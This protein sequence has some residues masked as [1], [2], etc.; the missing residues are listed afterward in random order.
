MEEKAFLEKLSN[1]VVKCYDKNGNI[2]QFKESRIQKYK[3]KFSSTGRET[4][5]LFLDGKP[6][7]GKNKKVCYICPTCQ[8]ES[9]IHL[10]RFLL[11]NTVHCSHC[12]E[13]EEKREWHSKVLKSYAKGEKIQLKDSLKKKREYNWETESETFKREY[14]ESHLTSEE[15]YSLIDKNYL[16]SINGIPIKDKK[17]VYYPHEPSTNAKKYRAMV[18]IDGKKQ[19]FGDKIEI[20]CENCGKIKSIGGCSSLGSIVNRVKT[21]N[22]QCKRCR[23]SNFTFRIKKFEEGLTYQSNLELNFIKK[24]KEK[25][26]RILDGPEIPYNFESKKLF[27][28]VDFYLPEFN[29]LVEL[30]DNHVWHKK[31]KSSG[32]WF[33]KQLS[34]EKYCAENNMKYFLIF[35]KNL[36]DFLKTLKR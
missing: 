3:S 16:Y 28:I 33:Q 29:Y 31:Q 10:S 32:K 22:F 9:T 36:D 2:V 17:I 35:P 24:C 34:A 14:F 25:N 20:I 5:T 26:I 7:M 1:S 30:K 8:K 21:D 15:F 19:S 18:E 12:S 13:T 27:Y 23:L 11:K 6:F 4:R